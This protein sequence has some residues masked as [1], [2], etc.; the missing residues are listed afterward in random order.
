MNIE[1]TKLTAKQEYSRT[2]EPFRWS[3]KMYIWLDG[4]TLL[5]NLQER[6]RRPHTF[7]KKEIIPLVIEKL[8]TTF[9][10]IYQMVK[11]EKWGWRQK[12]GCSM[13]PCSPGFVGVKQ[14][15][16]DIHASVKITE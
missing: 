15:A 16:Y 4:E 1:I 2:G 8:A 14:L 7:Y 10:E 9:P 12:C 11:D 3:N 6:R 13:C 5:E